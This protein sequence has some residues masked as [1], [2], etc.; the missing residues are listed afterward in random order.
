MA[1][2]SAAR[3]RNVGVFIDAENLFKGYGKLEI[4]DVSMADILELVE[5]EAG[6]EAG[7]GGIAVAHAYADWNRL[8]LEDFRRDVERDG[9]R[10]MQV[11]AAGAPTKNAADI[12]LVVDCLRFA[13]ERESIEVFVIVSGDGDFV[14]LVR[15]LHELGKYVVGA[16]LAEHDVNSLLREEADLYV[17]IPRPTVEKKAPAKKTAKKTAKKAQPEKKAEPKKQPEPKKKAKKAAPPPE[18]PPPSSTPNWHALA[19]DIGVVVKGPAS[20]PEQYKDAIAKLLATPKFHSYCDKLVA[21]GGTLPLLAM[22]IR[23][24]APQLSPSA[25]GVR[26]L[27][28]ALRFALAGTRYALAQGDDDAQP[29]LVMR[30]SKP[31]DMLPDLSLKEIR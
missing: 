28:R 25:V 10:T 24:A 30:R 23:A 18:E 5:R 21:R 31:A 22:A 4:P 12:E 16:T 17:S 15:R 13:T 8:G 19:K 1:R 6:E 3:Q 26:N 2:S 29:V 27:S 20:S 11:F 7:A 14:P 9:V